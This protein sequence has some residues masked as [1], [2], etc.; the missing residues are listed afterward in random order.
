MSPTTATPAADTPSQSPTSQANACQQLIQVMAGFWVARSVSAAA[1][2][3]IADQ[4]DP[5]RPRAVE[6]IAAATGTHAPSLYRLLRGLAGA[7]IFAEDSPGRFRHTPTSLLL[8][9]EVPGTMRASFESVLGGAHYRAWGAIEQALHNG[10]TAFD[11]V[12]GED[13]WAYFARNPHEQRTFDRTMTDWSELFNPPIAKAYDFSTIGTLM[14]VG[15]GHGALLRSILKAHPRVR[16]ILFD[17]P[18]V[19]DA[20][21]PYVAADGLADRCQVVGG[22]FFESVPAGADACLMKFIL[23]DWTDELSTKILRNVHRALPAGGRLLVV[24]SVVKPGNA[25]DLAKL[26]DLNMLAMTGGRER[27][28]AEF[29][30]L[31]A[32]AGF[33]LVKV[34]PT[35]CPLSVVEA[36]RR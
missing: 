8:R 16:G 34:H 2:L 35:E 33:E 15:G 32:G 9:S 4:I 27:T 24:D 31:F 3:K 26:M 21:R 28:E 6:E 25:P 36:V 19:A 1:T 20:A 18:H 14:D 23:H 17:Q 5:E 12:H 29:S 30:W 11:Q 22:S 7:G 13:V 10:K